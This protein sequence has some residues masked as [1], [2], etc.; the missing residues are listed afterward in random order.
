MNTDSYPIVLAYKTF[1]SVKDPY[2]TPVTDFDNV[3][4]NDMRAFDG[5]SGIF[6]AP[7]SGIYFFTYS[8]V[9]LRNMVFLETGFQKTPGNKMLHMSHLE[10]QHNNDAWGS[11][12]VQMI[13]RL[14]KGEN[15]ITLQNVMDNSVIPIPPSTMELETILEKTRIFTAFLLP[16]VFLLNI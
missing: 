8:Q 9:K 15:V 1:V 2:I 4:L 13:L 14:E 16:N 10:T 7:V 6:T 3:V 11:L 5:K 12:P